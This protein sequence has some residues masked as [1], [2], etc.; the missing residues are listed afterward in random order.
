M[1]TI[2]NAFLIAIS[3]VTV[4]IMA[5]IWPKLP[6]AFA[7][8]GS[9]LLRCLRVFGIVALIVVGV[10]LWW[11]MARQAHEHL[12][13]RD[14]AW[15]LQ[16]YQELPLTMRIIN[17]LLGRSSPV[18]VYDHNLNP[19]P[20]AVIYRGVH[21]PEASTAQMAYA[22]EQEKA[23][24][25]RGAITGDAA[26]SLP[27][28]GG[29]ARSI[30]NSATGK[31]ISGAW[32]KQPKQLPAPV[33]APLLAAP[34]GRVWKPEDALNLNTRTKLALGATADGAIVKWDMLDAPHL[35]FHGKT[36]GS[37]KTNALQTVAAGAARTGAHV[38]IMDRRR[39]K[40]WSDF[41]GKAEF[42]DTRDPRQFVA[43]VQRLRDVYQ[44]RDGVLGS[45][46]VPNIAS[47]EDPPQRLVVVISEFGALC[48]TSQAEG[49]LEDALHPL[50]LIMREAGAT[51]VHVLI[52]DQVVDQRWPRGIS[53]NAEPVT[54][55]LPIN[56]GSAGGYY[57]AHKLAPYTFHYQGA[58][59]GTWHMAPVLAV[60]LRNVRPVV[61]PVI[62]GSAIRSGV[63]ESVSSDVFPSVSPEVDPSPSKAGNA[64]N[65]MDNGKW[66]EF[67]LAYMSTEDGRGLWQS[68]A[69]GVRD[70]ARVMSRHDIGN[71]SAED[72]YVGIAS[73]MAARIR[74]ES[75]WGIDK[76]IEVEP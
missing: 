64:G 49:V 13:M 52:E 33:D 14:G 62:D 68:P 70:L 40:D 55:Y 19:T 54:G 34:P 63:S 57:H 25:V 31:F 2:G 74:K 35:R 66:Y 73:K 67:I 10:L 28:G 65:I 12:R 27:W 53:T 24:R 36:Q 6:A 71:Q 5:A 37:G 30:P 39:F 17:W 4:T 51:G 42:V 32:D 1:R 11:W 16:I 23:N 43:A 22:H 41:A 61:A 9:E 60:L 56:Y 59:F 58:T 18:T 48:A 46:G 76:A 7:V 72:S 29:D 8:A 3:I 45:H 50:Q 26:R 69:E 21:I 20:H 75:K 44:E 38:I 15:A 47:L